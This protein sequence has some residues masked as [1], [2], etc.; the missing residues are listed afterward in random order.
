MDDSILIWMDLET[1][2]I[3]PAQGEILEIAMKATTLNGQQV[4]S[5]VDRVFKYQREDLLLKMD[6]VVLSM[7]LKSGLIPRIWASVASD[8]DDIERANMRSWLEIGRWLTNLP[9]NLKTRYLAGNSIH[10][11]RAWLAHHHGHLLK[12]VSH[13][14]LDVSAFLLVRPDWREADTTAVIHRARPDMERAFNTYME[15]IYP[16]LLNA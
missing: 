14:M 2:G 13:R 9:G 4:A 12:Q 16:A 15:K 1:T 5:P 6:D 3:D 7:H 11:D 10:F 8:D